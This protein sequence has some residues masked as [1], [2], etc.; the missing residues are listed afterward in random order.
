MFVFC[1]AATEGTYCH[2]EKLVSPDCICFVLKGDD[3]FYVSEYSLEGS[4]PLLS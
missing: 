3:Y 2:D 4:A 1:A